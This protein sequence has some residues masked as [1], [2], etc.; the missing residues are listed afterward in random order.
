MPSNSADAEDHGYIAARS[1]A[2]AEWRLG[3]PLSSKS[4]QP[5]LCAPSPARNDQG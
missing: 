5:W 2:E 4:V 3:A 1:S